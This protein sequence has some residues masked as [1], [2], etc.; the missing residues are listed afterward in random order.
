M[1]LKLAIPSR[2]EKLDNRIGLIPKEKEMDRLAALDLFVRVVDAGSFSAVARHKNISQPAVSKAVAQLEEWL[3]VSLLLRSTRN[4]VPTEAGRNFYDR[5]KRT[6]EEADEAV[7]A[8]RGNAAGLQGRLRVSAAVCFARLHLVPRLPVFLAQ[9]PDLDIELIL[10][11]R[12]ID[13]VEEGID[14]ALRHGAMQNSD[15]TARKIAETRR[16]VMATPAYLERHGAPLTP[17]DLANHQAVIYTRDGGGV[18]WTFRQG[19]TEAPVSLQ[20]RVKVSASEGLRAAV[21]AGI[22]LAVTS[23]WTFTPEL[24]SG[25]VTAVL[26]DWELPIL[27]LFAVFPAGRFASAKARA[28]AAFVEQCMAERPRE[29][30]P[31][32]DRVAHLLPQAM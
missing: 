32:P 28:F 17:G 27:N 18:S 21:K 31:N 24:R 29:N 20:G 10:D 6:I 12:S 13:L 16:L 15:M 5:A 9:H 7:L 11:D 3:G 30:E 4:V 14:V 2:R 19:A 25:E 1:A 22:G 26:N 8:A 23:Q